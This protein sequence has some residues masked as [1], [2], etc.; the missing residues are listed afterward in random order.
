VSISGFDLAQARYDG[1]T[2]F[3]RELSDELGTNCLGFYEQTDTDDAFECKERTVCYL[4]GGV[5]CKEHDDVD[6][7]DG[8]TVHD[9][10]HREGCA[11]AS[12]AADARD[13]AL[14]HQQEVRDGR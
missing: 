7:C 12:C 5:V 11:S 4:C 1:A 3:V 2:P 9:L 8:E 6:D 10:C 13:D 14:L